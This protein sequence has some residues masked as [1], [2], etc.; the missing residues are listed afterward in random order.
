MAE[1]EIYRLEINVGIDGDEKTKKRL[2]AMDKYT[3]RSEKRMR[4]LDKMEASP[5]VKLEDKLSGP[6]KKIEGRV[7][8]FAKTAIKRFTAVAAAGAVLAGGFGLGSTMR[9]F[10]DYEQGLANVRAVTQASAEEMKILS[11]EARR[12]GRETVWSAVQ[13]T[14]AEQLLAQA[15]FSVQET[16][17]ALPGLLD[18]A[19]A[20]GLDL[21]AATDIAAGTLRAFGLEATQ[22]GQ[23]ADILAVAS[24][25][26]NSD[27]MGLGE[28]MKYVGPAA[29][30]MG[31]DL[32]QTT[33]ALGMLHDANIRGSQAGTTLRAALT[34]L[35]KPTKQSSDLMRQLGFNAFDSSG[36]MLPMYEVIEN[37]QRST[38]GLTEQ[39]RA[40]AMA[41]IF[42]QE[43][44][45]GMLALME[46]GPDRMKELT[47]S[48]Y[49]S[50]GAAKLMADTRLD[51]LAGQMELL[52]SATDELKLSLGERLAPYT[53]SFV[54]WT[55]S[56]IPLIT[57][58]VTDLVDR[59]QSFATKAY[60]AVKEFITG[61]K[62][63]IPTLMNIAPLIVGVGSAIA[64][65]K[66]GNQIQKGIKYFT[67]LKTLFSAT[68]VSSGG[69]GKAIAVL[70]GPV[71]Q[72][73]L[74]VGLLVTG[75]TL[76]YK[77]SET[78]RNKVHELKDSFVA[79]TSNLAGKAIPVIKGIGTAFIE[80]AKPIIDT[81]LPVIKNIA[82]ALMGFA[83]AAIPFVISGIDL[84]MGI[85]TA[86][87]VNILQP[88][89]AYI[90][91][92]FS[93]TI[94]TAFTVIGSI[95]TTVIETIT[96]VLSGLSLI[97]SGI[98][99]F[100]V[101]VFTG[102]WGQAWEGIKSITEGT[103]EVVKS[104]FTGLIDF[105]KEIPGHM[106][107]IGKNIMEGLADGIKTAISLPVNAIKNVGKS[108]ADGVK[109][110]LKIKSP[111]RVMMEYG[112][113]TTEGLAMGM[114]DKIPKLEAVVG[115]TYNVIAHEQN[116]ADKLSGRGSTTI[117]RVIERIKEIRPF[118]PG[119]D[120]G[121]PDPK[122][123]PRVAMAG[124]G[125]G[126]V[127]YQFEIGRPEFDFSGLGSGVEPEE[128]EEMV[129]EGLDKFG[130]ELLD[131]LRNI[132]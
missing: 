3:E 80:F 48:L 131:K 99:D 33:A 9:T 78:F 112:E 61:F 101:G 72:V 59:V 91:E 82:G 35:A 40:N 37:L 54:E 4:M 98:S 45:S 64:T 81:A 94:Q 47:Q 79:F 110:V 70:M 86:L 109:G 49:D 128:V 62:E 126:T 124:A 122:P 42:G 23:V 38:A 36:R 21:A 104:I 39:Q 68:A 65:I 2:S 111:S 113:F 25:A 77:N 20:G 132:K 56:N 83:S 92:V 76:A 119:Y 26:T 117:E 97:L 105:V 66:I 7:G 8:S 85:F 44:M 106:L 75:F 90:G 127:I 121:D 13:V 32:E 123:G 74:A 103:I 15:G 84:L 30:A 108:I 31:V 125:G 115:T 93:N 55:T 1:K 24:N 57:D 95:I 46:Q 118:N 69:V 114:E 27:V 130:Q 5:A 22:A 53:R 88:I 73:A 89:A 120:P 58:K 16:V 18:L 6:L 10:M 19:S 12:L 11:D 14:E 41:T 63:M 96:G 129:D 17:G 50:E 43:A 51:S 116:R 34:R 67:E 100:I 87:W 102:N 29:K 60:P 52:K 107:Q 28:A 71:G